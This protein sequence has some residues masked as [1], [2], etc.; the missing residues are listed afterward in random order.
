LAAKIEFEN[1]KVTNAKA[2]L[3]HAAHTQAVKHHAE[4]LNDIKKHE[5]FEKLAYF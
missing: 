5:E 3:T 4:A 1:A 2:S